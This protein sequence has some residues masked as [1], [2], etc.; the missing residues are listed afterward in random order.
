MKRIVFKKKTLFA[1]AAILFFISSCTKEK[2]TGV[3]SVI[4]FT[5]QQSFDGYY[6]DHNTGVSGVSNIQ[7]IIDNNYNYLFNVNLTSLTVANQNNNLASGGPAILYNCAEQTSDN[8]AYNLKLPVGS[9]TITASWF[10][11]TY[12][13]SNYSSS[14]STVLTSTTTFTIDAGNCT[15]IDLPAY[16]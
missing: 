14:L 12:N 9:H 1:L 8:A 3:N 5:D 2:N 7:I 6:S 13:N 10:Y 16:Q 15:Y 4:V 11:Y